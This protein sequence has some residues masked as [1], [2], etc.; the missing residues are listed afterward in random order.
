MLRE[1]R[2]SGD[3]LRSCLVHALTTEREEVMGLLI[4]EVRVFTIFKKIHFS[5]RLLAL[6]FC[7]YSFIFSSSSSSLSSSSLSSCSPL[8]L[9]VSSDL[10]C[11]VLSLLVVRR[12]D[13]R[14]D[15][16]EISDQQ[17]V[18]AAQYCEVCLR[19]STRFLKWKL[20]SPVFTW[21]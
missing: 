1:A 2:I 13:K 7:C 9:Q 18:E 8:P 21:F 3:V 12:S 6:L 11:S 10:V 14:Q 16:V 17:L 4:G 5:L 20:I 15:R 19:F